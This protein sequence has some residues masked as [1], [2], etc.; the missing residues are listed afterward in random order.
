MAKIKSTKIHESKGDVILNWITG[1]ILV[2]IVIVI[3]YPLLYVI[4]CSFSSSK[5]L[6]AG[7]VLLWPVDFS[8]EAYEFV[9]NFKQVWIG[10]RNSIFYTV[11]GGLITMCGTI[12]VAYPLSRTYM[13]GRTGYTMFFYL[14]TRISAGMIPLFIVKCGLG[15]YNTIWAILLEGVVSV[16]HILIL[17]TAFQSSIPGE[18][19]DAAMIDGAS[20]FQ[21]LVKIALPLAKATLSV[22]VLYTVVACWNEY[23]TS[24]LYL[25]DSNLYPLQL[26]LRP[27]M[28]AASAMSQI[29]T[30]GMGAG[31]QQMASSGLEN[32]RYA[33]IIISTVPALL[34]YFVVQKYFKGGVM[35]GSVKG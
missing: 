31:Y 1:L 32:V 23:F 30:S 29:S 19:F 24:M 13:Q 18:L 15:M 25:T 7:M 2:V 8:L 27:I 12:L 4:S 16:H 22:L 35:M 9:L 14:T 17:R 28:T 33:L 34:V 6:E 11:T 10:Y 3:G 21:S 26:V 5:A 20:Q